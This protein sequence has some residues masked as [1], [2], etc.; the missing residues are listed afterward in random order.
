MWPSGRSTALSSAT[1]A[2]RLP[3]TI[4]RSL[5]HEKSALTTSGLGVEPAR[6][7]VPLIT[8]SPNSTDRTDDDWDLLEATTEF[9]TGPF[10]LLVDRYYRAALAFC[11]QVLGDQQ[12]AEDV[13]QQG[14]VNIFRTRDRHERRAQ[15]KTF[16]FRVLLNLCINEL[17]RR[18]APVPISSLFDDDSGGDIFGDESSIDPAGSLEAAELQE[19]IRRGVLRLPPK[20]R[21]ALYL[22]EY[23]QL[24]Y[25]EIA[26]SLDA[27]LNEVKIWIFR[28]RNKLQEI[29]RPYLDKGESIP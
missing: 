14:F 24:P 4:S 1:A 22:R 8:D 17:N 19:M 6:E 29:L 7:R 25:A 3:S 5:V 9:S 21:A 20:H 26:Q 28:G 11:I 27:S 2:Q 16:L 15:F 23:M 18:P 10:S 13:V 12:K